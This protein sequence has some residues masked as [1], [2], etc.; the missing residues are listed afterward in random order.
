VS[1][2]VVDVVIVTYNSAAQIGPLL[3][4][5]QAGA[6]SLPYRAIVVDNSSQDATRDV[7]SSRADARLL[8]APNDG[9]ASGLNRGVAALGGA[10]P[11]LMLNPDCI[12][13]PGCIEALVQ[14]QQATG[15]GIVVP[16]IRSEDGVPARSL[17]RTPS[18][19]RSIGFGDS[20]WPA[21]S[22]VVTDEAS[23]R[24]RGQVDWATGAAMLVSRGCYEAVDGLDE[25]FFMYSE[26]TDLCFRARKLSYLTYFEPDAG[27]MHV[28]GASGQS[29]ELYAMQSVNRVRL[30]R[31]AHGL[32]AT[33]VFLLF[34]VARELGRSLTGDA[35]ARR[36]FEALLRPSRRPR[37][38]P[39]RGSLLRRSTPQRIAVS[40]AKMRT[41]SSRRP[42]SS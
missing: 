10:G 19:L 11:I 31:R 25:S 2:P 3:D 40:G 36:A 16:L 20:R 8:P 1:Q 22:E 38:L 18:L 37:Q 27:V 28:G 29:P 5:L 17:R 33:G 7:V 9:Y 4:S 30:Y 13:D 26:E 34:A 23:Y 32:V 12:L 15:A 41:R 24:R 6:G 21:L 35:E 42:S 39:W 14:A